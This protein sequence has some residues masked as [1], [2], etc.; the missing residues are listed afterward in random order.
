MK[1][2]GPSETVE[3]STKSAIVNTPAGLTRAC[4]MRMRRRRRM[5]KLKIVLLS[6]FEYHWFSLKLAVDAANPNRGFRV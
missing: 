4:R 3:F 2:N 5:M 1:G 6:M